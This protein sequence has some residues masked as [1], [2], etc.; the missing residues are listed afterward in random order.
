MRCAAGLAQQ[1]NSREREGKDQGKGETMARFGKPEL[2]DAISQ[3]EPA[4]GVVTSGQPVPIH[5][6]AVEVMREA[7]ASA[8]AR[9]ADAS[10]RERMVKIGRGNQQSGRQES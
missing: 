5:E 8:R 6:T 9:N 2:S 3:P 10:N 4:P 1:F 7:S